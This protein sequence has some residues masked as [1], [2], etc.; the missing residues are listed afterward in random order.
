MCFLLLLSLMLGHGG[1][2]QRSRQINLCDG[3]DPLCNTGTICVPRK[4]H[5]LNRFNPGEEAVKTVSL[6]RWEGMFWTYAMLFDPPRTRWH[7]HKSCS[8][9]AVVAL[10]ILWAV[11]SSVVQP[12]ISS[13]FRAP[14]SWLILFNYFGLSLPAS[15]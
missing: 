14:H 6:S 2:L 10:Q 13:P 9:G 12:A 5:F 3:E 11:Q 15:E 4:K 1:A 8:I 7:S